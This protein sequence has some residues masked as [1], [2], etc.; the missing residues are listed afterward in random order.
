MASIATLRDI[1]DALTRTGLESGNLETI[2][3]DLNTFFSILSKNEE[4][5]NILV[6]TAFEVEEKKSII[7]DLSSKLGVSGETKK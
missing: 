2:T 5:R 1:C 3:S 7:S 4:L 6:T